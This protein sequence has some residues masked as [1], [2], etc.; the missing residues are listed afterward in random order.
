MTRN[1]FEGIRTSFD[2]PAP[3]AQPVCVLKQSATIRWFQWLMLCVAAVFVGSPGFAQSDPLLQV[4]T[5]KGE[6]L[7]GLPI[8]WSKVDAVLLEPSGRMRH[9]DQEE[10]AGHQILNQ[11]FRPQSV[12]EASQLLEQELGPGYE[13]QINGSY[14]VAAPA[15]K[16]TRWRDRFQ[17][18][19]AGYTRYFEVRGWPVRQ[20]DFPLVV[21]VLPGRNSFTSYVSREASQPKNN[22]VGSYFPKSNRCVLYQLESGSGVDW[23]ETEATIVHEAIHQLAFNTGA[24][25]RLFANPLWL[26]EGLATMFE[27]PAVYDLRS[28]R[29]T[30]E[31]RMLPSRVQALQ[32]LL[33]DSTALAARL[34]N[35]IESDRAFQIDPQNSYTVAWAL[36]FY[37]A[38]RMPTEFGRYLQT[39]RSRGLGEYEVGQRVADFRSVFQMDPDSLTIQLQ[40]LYAR[41]SP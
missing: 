4:K 35:L 22:V 30:L 10:I 12:M 11:S 24:H 17:S 28:N 34:A 32:P 36:T 40:R 23:S 9:L 33:Q 31:S 1:T 38:E 29:S 3:W 2:L 27:Q 8:H 21:I 19:M 37:L 14:V 39:L 18:L 26:V 7:V 6:A 5:N 13:I 15:G 25:E 20:P 41:Q 16:T